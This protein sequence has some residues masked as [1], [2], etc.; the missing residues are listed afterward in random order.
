MKK[1]CLVLTLLLTTILV[2]A[3]KKYVIVPNKFSFSVRNNQYNLN[4][5]VKQFFKSEGFTTYFENEIS[6]D[7]N[8]C[9]AYQISLK[10]EKNNSRSQSMWVLVKDC[11]DNVVFKS[12]EGKS[13][14]LE[15]SRA[16]NES[17]KRALKSIE[18]KLVVRKVASKG[19]QVSPILKSEVFTFKKK[20]TKEWVL[21]SEDQVSKI[22][23]FKSSLKN[24]FI[25]YKNKTKGLFFKSK[26][27]WFFEYEANGAIVSQKIIVK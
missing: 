18:G 2:N 3:Q 20:T 14:F 1:N 7:F 5:T 21:V 16:Y 22:V 13:R 19:E 10:R 15:T 24:V 6:K 11:N 17:L 12:E 25:A 9:D 23:G 8:K 4:K 26:G 27:F